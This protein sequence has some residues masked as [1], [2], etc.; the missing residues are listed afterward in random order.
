M[1]FHNSEY[2]DLIYCNYSVRCC[3]TH[4]YVFAYTCHV[5]LL[6]LLLCV[7]TLLLLQL[8]CCCLLLPFVIV[9]QMANFVAGS[10]ILI[11]VFSFSSFKRIFNLMYPLA[12]LCRSYGLDLPTSLVIT[13][14]RGAKAN[15]IPPRRSLPCKYIYRCV[16]HVVLAI[17]S[18]LDQVLSRKRSSSR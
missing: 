13:D 7:A 10:F 18:D 4:E 5:L 2:L 9:C 15:V 12:V 8:Q 14:M 1:W 17:E 16:G 11:P 6:L 3:T